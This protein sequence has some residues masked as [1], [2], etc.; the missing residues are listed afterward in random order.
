MFAGNKKISSGRI[1]FRIGIG[2]I[3]TCGP[4]TSHSATPELPPVNSSSLI[5]GLPKLGTL[6]TSSLNAFR[7]R[8]WECREIQQQSRCGNKLQTSMCCLSVWERGATKPIG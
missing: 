8:K 7:R 3:T 4:P 6:A 1:T 5:D 2:T